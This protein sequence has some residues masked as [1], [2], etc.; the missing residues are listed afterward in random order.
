MTALF[1]E[2]APAFDDA[3]AVLHPGIEHAP[4]IGVHDH[5][6][7]PEAFACDFV[8]ATRDLRERLRTIAVDATTSASDH[9]PVLLELA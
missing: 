6:Q 3:W 2:R 7:W 4:T 1:D 8:F 9:Q 5:E